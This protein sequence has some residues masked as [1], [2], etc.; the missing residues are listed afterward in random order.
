MNIQELL[1]KKYGGLPVWAW[2]L[3]V[4]GGVLVG[5]YFYRRSKSTTTATSQ[6]ATTTNQSPL[7]PLQSAVGQEGYGNYTPTGGN[8]NQPGTTVINVGAPTNPSNWL[9][10]LYL[11][12]S[13]PVP[14][15]DQPGSAG[16]TT[17]GTQ[18][19]TIPGG[20]QVQ[21][22]GPEQVG[23]WLSNNTSELWYPV[24]Y[25]GQS[26]YVN[27]YY[28]SNASSS[29]N[30]QP[31]QQPTTTSVAAAQNG[32]IANTPGGTNVGGKNIGSVKKGDTLTLLS[33]SG[34]T[35]KYGT[36][37]NISTPTIS[38]GWVSSKT[39]GK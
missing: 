11:T 20:S 3:V 10:T 38:N 22:T 25:Q 36:Y 2:G 6:T 13:G 30:N 31:T 16:S 29:I 32:P 7:A 17:L 23:S 8:A 12:N 1:Q 19:A 5:V 34:V 39:I 28:V 24:V 21:A 15:Y 27:A 14:M 33:T 18:I 35:N 37:Y 4:I 9:T 26:G